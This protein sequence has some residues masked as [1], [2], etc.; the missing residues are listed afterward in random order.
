VVCLFEENKCIF[1]CQATVEEREN[2]IRNLLNDE[3]LSDCP[4]VQ[5]KHITFNEEREYLNDELYKQN[6]TLASNHLAVSPINNG[7]KITSFVGQ[8][9]LNAGLWVAT[10]IFLSIAIL[11]SFIS[12]V[13]SLV[14]IILNPVEPMLR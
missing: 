11:F 7:V 6:T 8:K 5:T 14:N 4:R 12:G 9:M 3:V 1:S 13:F 10:L 2:E